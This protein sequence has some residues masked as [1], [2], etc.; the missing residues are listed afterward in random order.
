[1]RILS[2][3]MATSLK[4]IPYNTPGSSLHHINTEGFITYD[5]IGAQSAIRLRQIASFKS[6]FLVNNHQAC[7]I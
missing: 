5:A 7:L 2:N 4:Q 3:K 6:P 1:M